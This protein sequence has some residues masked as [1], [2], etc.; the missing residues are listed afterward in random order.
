MKRLARVFTW[1]LAKPRAFLAVLQEFLH[2]R[3]GPLFDHSLEVV[4][5]RNHS[6]GIHSRAQC[7][8]PKHTRIL[9]IK[10][11]RFFFAMFRIRIHIL[12][13]IRGKEP[14]RYPSIRK[15]IYVRFCEFFMTFFL[16]LSSDE[17]RRIR[18]N[19]F[20]IRIRIRTVHR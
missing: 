2:W 13:G 16:L 10:N 4:V 1:L 15:E 14:D 5:G 17:N 20:W 18:I 8:Q 19:W 7:A 6:S 3:R 9:T 11:L 12:I